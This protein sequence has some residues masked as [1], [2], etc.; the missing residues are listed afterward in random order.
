MEWTRVRQTTWV[1][2][3]SFKMD[4]HFSSA[5]GLKGEGVFFNQ[6]KKTEIAICYKIN[7]VANRF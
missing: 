2:C 7:E 4:W 6:T 1:C 5:F 3:H